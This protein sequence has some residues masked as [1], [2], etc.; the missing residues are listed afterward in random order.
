[1]NEENQYH[2]LQIEN[3]HQIPY[4]CNCEELFEA[5]PQT[6]QSHLWIFGTIQARTSIAPDR[7]KEPWEMV[8]SPGRL[9]WALFWCCFRPTSEFAVCL[10][11][12]HRCLGK[13]SLGIHCFGP[14]GSRKTSVCS[15]IGHWSL[16][17]GKQSRLSECHCS[18]RA[19]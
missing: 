2:L 8:P 6:T 12:L 17:C 19:H 15:G 14:S 7:A 16:F 3:K 4:V 9:A 11:A 18:T 13:I 10:R 1:M 5:H